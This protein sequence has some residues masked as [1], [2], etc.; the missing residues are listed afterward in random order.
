MAALRSK[1]PQRGLRSVRRLMEMLPEALWRW[2]HSCFCPVP[3][4]SSG[5]LSLRSHERTTRG[6]SAETVIP[7]TPLFFLFSFLC[8]FPADSRPPSCHPIAPLVA[9]PPPLF[10]P[11]QTGLK[12]E[13][14]SGPV[15]ARSYLLIGKEKTA[16][17]LVPTLVEFTGQDIWRCKRSREPLRPCCRLL[18][19]PRPPCCLEPFSP[20]TFPCRFRSGL[21]KCIAGG[22][23]AQ[24]PRPFTNSPSGCVSL[25]FRPHP[26]AQV[27]SKV[28]D[29]VSSFLVS[30][31]FSFLHSSIRFVFC[32]VLL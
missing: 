14:L 31:F 12:K 32:F 22:S 8:A 1:A 16:A 2:S 25:T 19:A 9:V 7:V 5:S 28:P 21:V 30:V 6:A 20:A 18:V 15:L 24:K 10:S 17:V 23:S 4:M 11:R 26:A 27:S 3:L 13:P 29:L